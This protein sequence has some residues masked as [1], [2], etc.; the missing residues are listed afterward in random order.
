VS[1]PEP[2]PAD[3]AE[4]ADPAD[5]AEPADPADVAEPAGTPDGDGEMNVQRDSV[6]EPGF[7]D[8]SG[9]ARSHASRRAA[10]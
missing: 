10:R 8:G 9:T 6:F 5:A 3:A 7:Y 2:A 4:P 1:E